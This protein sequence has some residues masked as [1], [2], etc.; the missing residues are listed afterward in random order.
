VGDNGEARMD[1]VERAMETLVR[2]Q[3]H[4][5]EAQTH[6]EREHRQLLTA[7]VVLTDAVT[8]LAEEVRIGFAELRAAHAITDER[9]RILID[10]LRNPPRN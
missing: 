4:L 7:Q 9:F 8:K 1:R 3:T 6:L 10:S 5:L 2:S